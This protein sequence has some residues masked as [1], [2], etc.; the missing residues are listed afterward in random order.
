MSNLYELTSEYESL[1]A[2]FD[3]YEDGEAPVELQQLLSGAKMDMEEKIENT[4]IY[5]KRIKADIAKWKAEEDRLKKERFAMEKR[6][7]GLVSWLG[8]NM[9][10]NNFKSPRV[11]ITALDVSVVYDVK[12]AEVPEEYKR[13]RKPSREVNKPMVTEALNNG[14]V[15]SF[16][17]LVEK[18]RVK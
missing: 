1:F 4:G 9:G 10:K 2:Y 18:K 12:D 16:A 5:A 15:L 17:H 14:E 6:Y 13:D 7:A 3:M 8:Q 11:N